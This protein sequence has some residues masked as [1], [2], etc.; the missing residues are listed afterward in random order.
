MTWYFITFGGG[1]FR[2]RFMA[3]RLA[4]QARRVSGVTPIAVTDHTLAKYIG[5]EAAH[6]VANFA[7]RESQGYGLWLWKPLITQAILNRNDADGVI[8]ADAG[9]EL[10]VTTKSIERL[11]AWLGSTSIDGY[12]IW[13]VEGPWSDR[14]YS[15]RAVSD[16]LDLDS[17]ALNSRQIQA[18][19]WILAKTPDTLRFVDD[20]VRLAIDDE[21]SLLVDRSTPNDEDVEFVAHRH[22]QSIFSC[23]SKAYG[24]RA[25][26]NE[27][28]FGPDRWDSAGSSYPIWSIRNRRLL[29][30]NA[31]PTLRWLEGLVSRVYSGFTRHG[32]Q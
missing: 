7:R 26:P 23:L 29:S 3:K 11:H 20:W 6:E 22:D 15:R 25:V 19:A 13:Q 27:T 2:Y 14:M 1:A 30:G 16:R 18:T 21:H 28:H 24:W 17:A 32:V 5:S 10:N 31:S 8:Y 9:C 12:R 4:T